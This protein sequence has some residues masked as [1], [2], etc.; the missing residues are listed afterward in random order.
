MPIPVDGGHTPH[1]YPPHIEYGG[2]NPWANLQGFA[3]FRGWLGAMIANARTAALQGGAYQ[4]TPGATPGIGSAVGSALPFGQRPPPGQIVPQ[5]I[6]HG[7]QYAT[8]W[9]AQLAADYGWAWA[10]NSSPPDHYGAP[11]SSP[12]PGGYGTSYSQGAFAGGDPYGGLQPKGWNGA[13]RAYTSVGPGPGT[14]TP[15]PIGPFQT[16]ID[17][18]NADPNNPQDIAY[19]ANNYYR[20]DTAAARRAVVNAQQENT[21]SNVYGAGGIT[22][23]VA[24]PTTGY[25]TQASIA[26]AVQSGRATV[27]NPSQGYSPQQQ[28]ALNGEFYSVDTGL[29]QH[30]DGTWSPNP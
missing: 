7:G 27:T 8:T 24:D 23:N 1:A 21:L 10:G 12:P 22:G 4:A 28:A 29:Y 11:A 9:A 30:A 18:R 25:V 20:G 19:L 3:D 16:A 2:G 13:A 17:I 6:E 15:S 26:A 14:F 5:A